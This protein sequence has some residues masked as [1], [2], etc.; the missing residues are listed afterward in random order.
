[1]TS[2]K[3]YLLPGSLA[4]VESMNAYSFIHDNNDVFRIK[5]N[6]LMMIIGNSVTL[7]YLIALC[8][9]NIIEIYH[10]DLRKIE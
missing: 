5:K 8:N 1:M 6:T 4:I 2:F 7:N 3:P 9:D 10:Y